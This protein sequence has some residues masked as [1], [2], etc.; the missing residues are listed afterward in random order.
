MAIM[1][2]QNFTVEEL[3]ARAEY[4]G[5]ENFWYRHFSGGFSIFLMPALP[6]LSYHPFSRNI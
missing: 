1:A 4:N 6:F 5:Y 2:K 3:L